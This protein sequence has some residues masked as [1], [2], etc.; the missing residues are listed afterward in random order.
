M[1]RT[2]GDGTLWFAGRCAPA[3]DRPYVIP[4]LSTHELSP[5]DRQQIERLVAQQRPGAGGK[6]NWMQAQ[7]A[8]VVIVSTGMLRGPRSG[9]GY[10]FRATK[11]DA[12]WGVEEVDQWRA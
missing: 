5:S 6:I 11:R 10:P 3:A 8:D 12:Q 2:G 9:G 4:H 7:R 1:Q